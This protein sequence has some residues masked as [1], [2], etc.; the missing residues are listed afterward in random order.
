M[1]VAIGQGFVVTSVS[2]GYATLCWPCRDA[3]LDLCYPLY[4]RAIGEAPVVDSAQDGPYS[5]V[6][7]APPDA[8]APGSD[9]VATATA[10]M[11]DGGGK[12][13]VPSMLLKRLL[14]LLIVLSAS[15]VAWFDPPF[16]AVVSILGA[17]GG[18]S[19]SAI[20]CPFPRARLTMTRTLVYLLS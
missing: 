10:S 5:T 7:A 15:S 9:G 19:T 17:V 2:C 14:A 1:L 8:P 3:I 11:S 20:L 16:G 12:T 18:E 6:T 4:L 13:R